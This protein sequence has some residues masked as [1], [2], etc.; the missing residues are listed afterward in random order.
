MG[1]EL[2]WTDLDQYR[3]ASRDLLTGAYRALGREALAGIV[4]VHTAHR[5]LTSVNVLTAAR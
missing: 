2:H 4:E 1:I 5:D 3:L